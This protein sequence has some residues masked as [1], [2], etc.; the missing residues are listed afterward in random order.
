MSDFGKKIAA[1]A[2]FGLLCFASGRWLAPTKIEIK[3]EIVTVES[4][5]KEET[6]NVS[7]DASRDKRVE[8]VITEI[9]RPDGT[10]ETSTRVVEDS[11]T[12][13]Q[14]DSAAVN[15]ETSDKASTEKSSETIERS[16]GKLSI[17][18][19]GGASPSLSN[20]LNLGPLEYGVHVQRNF[21]DPVTIGVWVISAGSGGIS[22]GLMF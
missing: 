6:K 17:A 4:T 2:I 15:R 20:G 9:V 18:L 14:S 12:V 22:I 10:R 3:K 19:L 5:K 21:I 8:K 1:L 13:R 7:T 16:S 11:R